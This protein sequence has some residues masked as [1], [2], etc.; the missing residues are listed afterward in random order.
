MSSETTPL[1]TG[2]VDQSYGS[3]PT[4]VSVSSQ[5]EE[6]IVKDGVEDGSL[7]RVQL[8]PKEFWLMLLGLFMTVFL[9]ALD[10]TIVATLVSDIGSYF[11]ASHITSW[12]GGAYLLSVCCFTPLYGRLCNIIGRRASSLLAVGVFTIG[13]IGCAFAPTMNTLILARAIAGMGGGGIMT[14]SSVV[15]SDVVPLRS[16]G[17]W[18]GCLNVLFGAGSGIGGPLGGY[19]SDT[20]GWRSAFIIQ[21][22]FLLFAMVLVSSYLHI[23]IPPSP[24]GKV[25]SMRSRLARIDYAGSVTLV[26][27]IG[28]FLLGISLKTSSELLWSDPRVWGLFV[29]SGVS[30][31]AFLWV[32]AFFAAEPVLPL[33]LLRE[34]GPLVVAINNFLLAMIAFITLYTV[35]LYFVAVQHATSSVAGSHLIPNSIALSIGSLS[36]GWYLRYSGRYYKATNFSVFLVLVSCVILATWNEE[37]TP[38]WLFWIG[39]VPFGFGSSAAITSTLIA[40]IASVPRDQ[41]AVAT[42]ISYTFRTSGQVLGVSLSGALTQAVLQSELSKRI[43]GEG[44]QAVIEK[45]RH[46]TSYIST[47][48]PLLQQQAT[49]SYAKS[50]KAVFMVQAGLAFLAIL[51]TLCLPEYPLDGN[52]GGAEQAKV[53][54]K[55]KDVER[56]AAGVGGG[57][58]EEE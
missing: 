35:P 14:V 17:L 31:L 11:N 9:G 25:H 53:A 16:R 54:K 45:I 38:R 55:S 30:G 43:T 23:P 51:V 33:T 4:A 48:P 57:R 49:Q 40:M 56:A 3:T 26:F 12:L 24:D 2:D 7:P 21:I 47:L 19:L 22:P 18:Q 32:E 44:S 34:R 20:L 37:T 1:R 52:G 13:T 8:T 5:E 39:V 27:F 6:E 58:R 28:S 46:S 10:T 36:T 41:M 29:T 42:G 50:L 15:L